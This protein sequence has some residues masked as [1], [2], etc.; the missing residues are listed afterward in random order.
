M[1]V[2]GL[3]KWFGDIFV[4]DDVDL[5]FN[6]GEIYVLFGENGVGKFMF[7]KMFYGFL[8]FDGGEICWNG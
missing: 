3:I 6:K 2:C 8:E 5:I 4:N 1:E 7:V